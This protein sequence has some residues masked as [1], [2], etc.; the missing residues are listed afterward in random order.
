MR[1]LATFCL[2]LVA[3]PR[4]RRLWPA[5][6]RLSRRSMHP[7]TRSTRL[8]RSQR[9]D[10][11]FTSRSL[12]ALRQRTRVVHR[13]RRGRGSR[14]RSLY[15]WAGFVQCLEDKAHAVTLDFTTPTAA[16]PKAEIGR[17]DLDLAYDPAGKTIKGTATL[18]LIPLGSDPPPG[19][20]S[21]LPD[22]RTAY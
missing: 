9:P 15:R 17:L 14:L 7:Q 13:F 3:L 11:N 5:R 19:E 6:P 16:S 12:I 21:G 1:S 10:E 2:I 20:G 8:C 22:R 18:R 4:C